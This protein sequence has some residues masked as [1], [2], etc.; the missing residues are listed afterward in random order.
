VDGPCG[1]NVSHGVRGWIAHI[2][3]RLAGRVI[4]KWFRKKSEAKKWLKDQLKLFRKIG[5][6]EWVPTRA[7]LM[8]FER[9]AALMTLAS[10][11]GLKLAS[12]L[13]IVTRSVLYLLFQIASRRGHIALTARHLPFS[14]LDSAAPG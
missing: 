8:E 7:Q 3:K 10:A 1:R 4:K 5:E 12:V 2:G 14:H 13:D 11:E 9:V 6:T